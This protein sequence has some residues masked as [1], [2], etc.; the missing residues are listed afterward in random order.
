MLYEVITGGHQVERGNPKDVAAFEFGV[1]RA[2]VRPVD[3]LPERE[4]IGLG[5]RRKHDLSA[6]LELPYFGQLPG[7][8]CVH[9]VHH[10]LETRI[11]PERV[12]RGILLQVKPPLETPS[13]IDGLAQSGDRQIALSPQRNN[14]V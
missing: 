11:A 1:Q 4:I 10:Q 5:S 13:R 2:Q 8:F 9:L 7:H 6:G 12:E 3:A 14:F